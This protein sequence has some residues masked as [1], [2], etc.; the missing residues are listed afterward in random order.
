MLDP[1]SLPYVQRGVLE[2]LVLALGAGVLGTWI[3]LRGLAFQSHAVGTAAFPGLVL[4]D[5][6]GFAPA[7][8]ALG[9]ALVMTGAVAILARRPHTSSDS[10][11]AIVLVAMLAAGI[12]LASDVFRSGSNVDS[13]LFGS[14]LL[15]SP[16][17][18]A[19]AAGAAAAA[20]GASLLL[21]RRWLATGFDADAA[22]ALGARSRLPEAVL[23]LVVAVT[24]IAA[25]TTVGALMVAALLVVPAATTR[26]LIDRVR[27]WQL[28]TVALAAVEGTGGIWL[29]VE[30]NAPP[31]ATIAVLGGGVFLVALAVR[32]ARRARSPRLLPVAAALACLA[33]GAAGCGASGGGG[34][35]QLEV[36]ATTTQIADFARNVGGDRVRVVQVLQPNTDPH[37]YEP[38][39]ADVAAVSRA[40]IILTNGD[41][42]DAWI[43]KVVAESGGSPQVIDLGESVP[44]RLP[45][46]S[47]GPEAS[48]VD[49][50][51]WHDPLNAQAAVATIRETFDRARPGDEK[52]FQTD[53]TSYL[54]KL[55]ALDRGIAG[56]LR[57]IPA[58][59]R[60]LVTDHDA[61]GYF[62]TR[63]G[64][65][66]VGAVVPSQSTQAQPSAADVRKLADEIR[67][68]GVTAI[69]PESSLNP[70]LAQAIAREAGANAGLVLYGDTLGPKG[71][72]GATYLGMMASNADAMARGFTGGRARCG[73]PGIS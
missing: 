20:L 34:S 44:V 51:W 27:P 37:E 7:L 39:P 72:P 50:H 58:G 56:C 21:G 41:G 45:G 23:L 12:V 67:A 69:F 53:A 68:Q 47:T 29:A 65:T 70:K 5:G 71:S 73:I 24:T 38:R 17:D 9:A 61:F 10:R 25:L 42:L 32:A 11:T 52:I 30:T 64:V 48:R 16:A 36:V 59:R 1:F 63:Y 4:A 57:A 62:A 15:T 33:L 54:T 31:G 19:F 66:V 13:L 2:V 46:E 43:G 3:V 18:I 14:V 60:R 49:P 35:G 26:L 28:A 6:L 8:G 40:K 22:H 55:G